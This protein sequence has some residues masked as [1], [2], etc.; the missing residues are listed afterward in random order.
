MWSFAAQNS[1][2]NNGTAGRHGWRLVSTCAEFGFA[3]LR[4]LKIRMDADF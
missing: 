2:F 1:M 4:K 3:K